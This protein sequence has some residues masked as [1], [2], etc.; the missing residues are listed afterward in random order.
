MNQKK[1]LT[2]QSLKPIVPVRPV[3]LEVDNIGRISNPVT[4]DS[5]FVIGES[6]NAGNDKVTRRQVN[7]T[8]RNIFRDEVHKPVDN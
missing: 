2:R 6:I 5:L 3:L 4:M 8:S 7:I 1:A